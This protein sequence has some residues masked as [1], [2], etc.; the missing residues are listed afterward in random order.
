MSTPNFF[1]DKEA[2]LNLCLRNAIKFAIGDIRY[3][4]DLANQLKFA[5]ENSNRETR[6][7]LQAIFKNE[8]Y[9]KD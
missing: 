1:K 6:D 3:T 7:L 5:Y 4:R 9:L 2:I 8:G